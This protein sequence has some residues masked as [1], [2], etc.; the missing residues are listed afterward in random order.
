M[1]RLQLPRPGDALPPSKP[2]HRTAP[3]P[4][5]G[6]ARPAA[7]A[8]AAGERRAKEQF[9]PLRRK[10]PGLRNLGNT[11]F[12]AAV[13][14]VLYHRPGVVH[15]PA[16]AAKADASEAAA[17]LPEALAALFSEMQE[18]EG[19]VVQP[20]AFFQSLRQAA[21]GVSQL[22]EARQHDAQ[23]FFHFL[24]SGSAASGGGG[25][26]EPAAP[27]KRRRAAAGSEPEPVARAPEAAFGRQFEGRRLCATRC[28]ECETVTRR[29]E[30]FVD[31]SL[32]A[33]SGASVVSALADFTGRERLR[34][35]NKFACSVCRA[36]TPAERWIE[37]DR[38]PALLTLHLQIFGYGADAKAATAIPTQLS[39]APWCA[40]ETADA[41]YEL[42]GLVCHRGS[43]PRSGHYYSYTRLGNQWVKCDDSSTAAVTTAEIRALL[44]P[45]PTT[46][47]RGASTPYLLMYQRTSV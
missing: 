11:C 12:A 13:L 16:P 28:L 25:D 6:S 41:K 38:L 32:S 20:Y 14:Q 26:A 7:A 19:R 18:A 1:S 3:S 46:S 4:S 39:L 43:S 29:F 9:E 23:E 8:A 31:I 35:S 21:T 33:R 40:A 42:Y 37:F 24:L 45:L 10:F 34:G 36:L 30:T 47:T 2:K 5:K 27:T 44:Q 15:P 17:P 22:S